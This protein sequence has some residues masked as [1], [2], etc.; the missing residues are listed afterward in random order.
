GEF[1]NGTSSNGNGAALEFPI[2]SAAF[3]GAQPINQWMLGSQNC[4]NFPTGCATAP[5]AAY[6][7]IVS[8]GMLVNTS[9]VHITQGGGFNEVPMNPD[10][11]PSTVQEYS[12]GIE[13][14]LPF[15]TGVQVTYIGNHSYN[16]LETDPI[17]FTVPRANCA[18]AGFTGDAL[19][20]CVSQSIPAD[21]RAYGVFAT[22]SVSNYTSQF[23]YNGY[24][25][26]NELEAQVQHTFGGGL[27]VQAYFTWLKALTTS[28]TTLLGES[29]LTL[30]P[31][32]VT[33][34]YNIANPLT[35]GD[36]VSQRLARLYA[37]D[38]NLPAKTIQF[39]A[40]YTLPFGKGKRF[41][42]NAHGLLNAIVS[43]YS[44]SPFF[45]WHSGLPFMPWATGTGQ[46]ALSSPYYLAP[47]K[48]GKLPKGQRTRSQWFN[49]SVWD[50]NNANTGGPPY[51][52]QT[53][54]YYGNIPSDSYHNDFPN[55]IPRNYMTGPGFNQMDAD[56]YKVTPL[57][58]NLTFN[59]EAQFLNIYNH[60]NLGLPN[61]NGHILV[62]N[63]T[64][65][66]ILLQ[67][68]FVF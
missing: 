66:H 20:A 11:K 46:P 53:F 13:R 19:A 7:N 14:Q 8:P 5:S 43:G 62:G 40:Q 27:L 26:T 61:N 1:L 44:L 58:R 30:P 15:N 33:P 10:Y 34:G 23:L 56:V 2:A 41:L 4:T 65:R 9:A 51:Q 18:A 37:P 52:N 57:W 45:E 6:P 59:F 22:S 3:A 12:L 29:D 50:A 21:T 32:S 17:N 35:S 25:N 68:K 49:A 67:G 47:G 28:E 24:A 48:T 63:G 54:I 42:G 60:I 31:A 36:T 38:S 16:L 64:P 55:N 39:N